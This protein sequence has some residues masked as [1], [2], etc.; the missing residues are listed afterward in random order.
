M[1]DVTGASLCAQVVHTAQTVS[2]EHDEKVLLH[3]AWTTQAKN[4]RPSRGAAEESHNL[5]HG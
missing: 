5:V 3:R 4:V 2:A 1:L